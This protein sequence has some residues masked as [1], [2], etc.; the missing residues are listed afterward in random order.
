MSA[1]APQ[2]SDVLE[3]LELVKQATAYGRSCE[4]RIEELQAELS[5]AKKAAE[6]PA[7]MSVEL[8]KVAARDA[9][10]ITEKLASRHIVTEDEAAEL[11]ADIQQDP[12][13]L[14]KIANILLEFSP[15]FSLPANSGGRGIKSQTNVAK[16][17]GPF[18][19]ISDWCSE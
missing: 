9:K 7:P 16:T 5:V 19:P 18:G 2:Q 4:A 10:A 3:L 6:K 12:R 17:K 11:A 13:T 15:E 14:L 1:F 8:V